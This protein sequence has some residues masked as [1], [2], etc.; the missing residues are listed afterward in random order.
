M[1]IDNFRKKVWT[2]FRGTA[3]NRL[4]VDPSNPMCVDNCPNIEGM[5]SPRK[6]CLLNLAYGL[7]PADEAY[8]EVGTYHGKSL[9]SAML[10]NPPRTTYACDN[11]S[12]FDVNSFNITKDNLLQYGLQNLVTF[13]DMNFRNI[14]TPTHL[15][16]K[17]GVYFYDGAHDYQSQF[18][19][20]ALVEPFLADEALAI[21][22][23]WRFGLDSGSYACEATLDATEK[24]PNEWKLLYEL[25]ARFNGDRKLWWNGVGVLSFNR[26]KR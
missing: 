7:L 22:D 10:S 16:C 1:N 5:T 18:D 4:D 15:P 26:T 24:S 9:I 23:D 6:Q 20:I 8:L 19:A 2:R 25:K 21:V 12:E 11:F 17:L 3:R 13:Y 14:Y